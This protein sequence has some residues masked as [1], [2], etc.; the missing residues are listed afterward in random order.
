MKTKDFNSQQHAKI[1]TL[2]K[3]KTVEYP[4]GQ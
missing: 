2:N 1:N 4:R 3:Q